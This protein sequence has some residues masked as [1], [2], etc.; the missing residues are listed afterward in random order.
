MD[1]ELRKFT[2]FVIIKGRNTGLFTSFDEAR[3]QVI[4]K[5]KEAL[6]EMTQLMGQPAPPKCPSTVVT[7]NGR[8]APLCRWINCIP[9]SE[10]ASGAYAVNLSMEELLQKVCYGASLP[11]PSYFRIELG[12]RDT[13]VMYAFSVVLPGNVH[14]KGRYSPLDT[15]A[16]KDATY[17]MLQKVLHITD[18]EIRDFNYLKAKMLERANN[19]LSEE[20]QCLEEKCRL[21]GYNSSLDNVSP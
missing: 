5:E 11:P 2:Y 16:K 21:H 15:D 20:V 18:Q 12:V 1:A 13:G 14:A 6:D 4:E 8:R 10:V 7:K 3:A 9:P 17:N 19:A